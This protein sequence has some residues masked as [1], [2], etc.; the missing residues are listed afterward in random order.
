MKKLIFIFTTLMSSQV[1]ATDVADC[2]NPQNSYEIQKCMSKNFTDLKTELNKIYKKLYAQT[3]AKKELDAAQKAWLKYRELQ[4]GDFIAVDTDYSP[5]SAA[6][7][8]DCQST[9]NLQRID[10]L[11]T[12]LS[13]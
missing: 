12:L 5:A 11:K 4:C 13:K 2:D 3:E 9:L 1:F 7:E 6:F 10:F 8:L